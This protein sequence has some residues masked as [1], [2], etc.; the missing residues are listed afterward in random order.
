MVADGKSCG[1]LPN[2]CSRIE[3]APMIFLDNDTAKIKL[4]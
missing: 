1:T 4:H 3:V 2:R